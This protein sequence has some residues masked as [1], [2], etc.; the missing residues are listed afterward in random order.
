ME[1]KFVITIG[2]EFG[3]GGREIGEMV[4]AQLGIDFYDKKLI[5]IASQKSGIN[6]ELF[7]NADESKS[8]SLIGSLFGLRTAPA[9]EVPSGYFLSNETLFKIQSDVIREIASEKSALFVGR[10]AD[11]LLQDYNLCIN[12][13][14]T[15]SQ[16]DKIERV[17]ARSEV[18]P[19]KATAL[20][21]KMDKKRAAYYNYFSNKKWADIHSYDLCINSSLLG[22]KGTSNLIVQLVNELLHSCG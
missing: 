19:D 6:K 2:R 18:L 20:I 5:E 12:I 10:C 21:E 1:S 17:C 7:E 16:E 3:S 15:A 9:N 22:I 13:F 8:Y 14:I 4:A 11:Y